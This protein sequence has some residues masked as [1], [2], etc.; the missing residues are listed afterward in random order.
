[1]T[2][3]FGAAEL[4]DRRAADF[5]AAHESAGR[6]WRRF[7][8]L[9]LAAFILA[10]ASVWWMASA[11]RSAV[12]LPALAIVV[13]LGGFAVLVR[14][15]SRARAR[16][17]RLRDL[18][19]MAEEGG[20]RVR[21][22]WAAIEQR[23]WPPVPVSHRYALDLDVF[24]SASLAQLFPALSL[25]PGRTT[26]GT[27]LLNPASTADARSRQQAV[28]ELKSNIDFRDELVLHT[29]RM[30]TS[31]ARL[32]GFKDWAAQSGWRA[33][34]GWLA[35]TTIA[36]PVAAALLAV[37]Q[38]FGLVAHAYWLIPLVLG[39]IVTLRFRKQ[40]QAE[41]LKIQGER[42]V[43][44][45][46][47]RIASL[48]SESEWNAPLLRE[49]SAQLGNGDAGAARSM[50]SL[51]TLADCTDVRLSPMLHFIVQA[52][53]MWDFHVVRFLNNWK[54]S[55][56]KK[57][58]SWMDAIGAFEG[59]S[60]LATLAHD[61]TDWVFPRMDVPGP[62]AIE[63]AALG[64]PLLDAKSAVVNDVKVGPSGTLLFVT[65]SNMAGKS[66]LLR[67]I[68]LNVVL[69]RA[70]SV[71]CASSMSCPPVSLYTSMRVQDSLERGVS[72]FMAEL[73]RLKLIVDAAVAAHESGATCVLY[74]LDEILH[75]TNSAER[76][77]AARQVLMR[78]VSVGAIGAVT[79][80][81]L[82]LAD[83]E[84]FTRIATHVHFQEQFTRS[85][86][87]KPA[88]SFDYK[89]RP[90]KAESSNALKLLEL[91]GLGTTR[92]SGAD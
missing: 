71:V 90:G 35:A 70:G 32:R 77:I 40:L 63:A 83:T 48:I 66:T 12:L 82:Q 67:A 62:V 18:I 85:A 41:L 27:W 58:A 2:A 44:R 29:R 76:T 45:S 28:E 78:L 54:R 59:L 68:G 14:A 75:G 31:E 5:R 46:Y 37:A 91:V 72:Y 73:E 21:R 24:G 74:L 7:A 57:V 20:H 1:V 64:H 17:Q 10:A 47:G 23:S 25:A 16:V 9:R 34:N 4:Y 56:G 36:V 22:E 11:G 13:T 86:D 87:G 38:G 53:T 51:E 3:D 65:G 61:N 49:L 92:Q 26:L 80:H 30:N 42:N 8:N 69:A 81:D 84:D 79:T 43:L 33:D 50:R 55:T 6:R 39:G 89:L 19:E 15:S 88:M 60:A 52:L